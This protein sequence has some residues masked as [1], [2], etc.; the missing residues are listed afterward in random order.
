LVLFLHGFPEFWWCWHSQLVAVAEAGHHAAAVDLRGHGDSDKP[1]RGYDGWTLTGDVAGLVRALGARTAHL[2][3][4]GW[5]GLIAW[6]TAAL[7][8]RLVRSVTAI[9]APHPLT[10]RTRV[11]RGLVRDVVA[12]MR[13]RAP[14]MTSVTGLV[15][16]QVPVLPERALTRNDAALVG[17]LIRAWSAQARRDTPEI[18]EAVERNRRAMLIPG[19]AHCTLESPR[20]AMRSQFRADGRRFA[21]TLRDR[22]GPPVL[23]IHGAVDPVID[24]VTAADSMPWRGPGSRYR[25]L[26][27]VGHFPHHEAAEQVNELLVDFLTPGGGRRPV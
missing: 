22:D 9:S 16:A 5:G 8:P 2:V 27:E 13:P 15:A 12:A 17:E 3:G 4:H 14:G 7:H 24:E 23:Q 10:L 1:P 19:T 11:G 26:P 20:W 18:A 21:R 6:A 25:V